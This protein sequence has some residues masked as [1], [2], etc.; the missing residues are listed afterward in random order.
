LGRNPRVTSAEPGLRSDLT[1][2]GI[3]AGIPAAPTPPKITVPLYKRGLSLPTTARS[4]AVIRN[5]FAMPVPDLSHPFRQAG[6]L[7]RFA[8]LLGNLLEEAVEEMLIDYER[9]GV[10]LRFQHC[11]FSLRG[12]FAVDHSVASSCL[13][14]RLQNR[15]QS[16]ATEEHGARFTPR[17]R[18]TSYLRP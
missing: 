17:S 5:R 6:E 1:S 15:R 12:R 18:V 3:L 10:S 2:T 8:S 4:L 13:P 11:R 9:A 14:K 7:A 16:R